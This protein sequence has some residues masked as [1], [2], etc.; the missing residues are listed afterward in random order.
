MSLAPRRPDPAVVADVAVSCFIAAVST[1]W[2]HQF[3]LGGLAYGGLVGAAL[4]WRRRHPLV[5]L[6]VVAALSALAAPIEV[7]GTRLHEGMLLL[8]LAT[9]EYAV[10][11]HSRTVRAAV[12]GGFAALLAAAVLV[13]ARP[14]MGPG[15][16]PIS[17]SALLNALSGLA[18]YAAVVGAAALSVRIYRQQRATAEDRRAAADRERAQLT[19]V[20]VAEERAAIAR[21]LHDIVAHSLSVMILQA[22]GGAYA[23]DHDPERAR[24]ALHTISATGGDALEEIRNLVQIL[25]GDGDSGT[26]ADHAPPGRVTTVVERARA[27]GL[28]VDLV[29]DGTPPQ[30]TGGVALAVYRIVQE[31]LTN[32]LK[33]AGPA[34]SASVRVRY[35][36]RAVDVEVTDD[37]YGGTPTPGGHGLVGMRERALLFGGTFEA[38]P[39]LGGGWRVRARIP[40]AGEAVPA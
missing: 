24:R 31:S 25:R 9:A 6:A 40:S 16:A 28:A 30:L 4:W 26:G 15:W 13:L 12:G 11:V 37:G 39:V 21:E 19:R 29:Q 5:V 17:L 14:A 27:A 35:S 23:L 22:N 36:A 18:G 38:G 33:H 32:T 1:W 3:P 34:P 10:V 8:S 20:A 7:D 2:W